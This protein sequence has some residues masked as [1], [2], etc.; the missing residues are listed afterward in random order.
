MSTSTAASFKFAF[1]TLALVA[2]STASAG[3]PLVLTG[4]E[5]N[6]TM[7]LTPKALTALR[8]VGMSLVET[9]NTKRLPDV[10]AIDFRGK[11]VSV[12]VYAMP[13]T[14]TDIS[15]AMVKGALPVKVNS[16]AAVGSALTI[17]SPETGAKM[18]LANFNIDFNKHIVYA[19]IIDTLTKKTLKAQPLYTFVDVRVGKAVLNGLK[20]NVDSEIGTLVFTP[21][22]VT[23]LSEGLFVGDTLAETLKPLDWGTIVVKVTSDMRAK[24]VNAAAFVYK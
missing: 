8:A 2:A 24:K 12:P 22:A 4:F 11:E 20:L 14:K 21:S 1:A 13:A 7:T 9:G 5:A 19:D 3:I 16:G 6:A 17:D 15:L 18:I 10:K 23:Q